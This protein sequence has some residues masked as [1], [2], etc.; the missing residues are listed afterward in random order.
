MGIPF[1]RTGAS[2]SLGG[3]TF[4][5]IRLYFQHNYDTIRFP[6]DISG[7]ICGGLIFVV[8]LG[9]AMSG[10]CDADNLGGVDVPLTLFPSPRGRPAAS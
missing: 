5:Q 6:D 9:N 4:R 1:L 2:S 3:S 8:G 7:E 10:L